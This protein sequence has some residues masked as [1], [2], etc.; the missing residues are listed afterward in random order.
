MPFSQV[1]LSGSTTLSRIRPMCWI[2]KSTTSLSCNGPRPSWL[3]PQAMTSPELSVMMVE[4]NS[5]SS[6]TRCSMSSVPQLSIDRE[7]HKHIVGI[8]DL[9][10]GRDARPEG[11][12]RIERLSEPTARLPCPPAL[13]ARRHIDHSRVA[14]NSAAPVLSFHFL[15]RLLDDE[16][17]LRLVHEDPWLSEFRQ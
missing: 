5:T 4:A 3:V 9:V 7:A 10:E 1:R 2:S 15:G 8:R 17:K 14:K 12:K 6:G 13:A 16:R 11:R